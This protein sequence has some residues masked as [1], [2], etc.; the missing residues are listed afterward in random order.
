[1]GIFDKFRKRKVTSTIDSEVVSRRKTKILGRDKRL[2]THD[3]D[4]ADISAEIVTKQTKQ[5]EITIEP[6][7]TKSKKKKSKKKSKRG[8]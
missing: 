2:I 6:R 1:M 3:S 8:K 7:N 5:L 4:K